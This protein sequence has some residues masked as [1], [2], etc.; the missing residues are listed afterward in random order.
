[1]CA[2]SESSVNQQT[3][4]RLVITMTKGEPWLRGKGIHWRHILPL[5]EVE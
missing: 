1:M 3:I 4:M 5:T 2:V